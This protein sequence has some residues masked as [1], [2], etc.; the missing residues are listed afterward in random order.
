MPPLSLRREHFH[1]LV[2]VIPDVRMPRD[3]F[4]FL[5]YATR[6]EYKI[7]RAGIDCVMRH[8]GMLCGFVLCEGD[9]AALLHSLQ[10]KCAIGRGSGKDDRDPTGA[11]ILCQGT[12]ELVNR[13][14]Q[15]R[16]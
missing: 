2:V 6:G 16:R 4:Q 3:S 9:P 8:G 12:K 1:Q 7:D 5:H 14:M 11:L 10:A 13:K 15:A